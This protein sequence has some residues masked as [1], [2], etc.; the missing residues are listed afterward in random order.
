MQVDQALQLRA[1][2][3]LRE[4]GAAVEGAENSNAAAWADFNQD[5]RLDVL[6]LGARN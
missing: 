3:V 1:R 4:L 5:G 6:V 2:R